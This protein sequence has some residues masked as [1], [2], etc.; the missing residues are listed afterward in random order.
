MKHLPQ[1]L[2]R[3]IYGFDPTFHNEFAK[4]LA[5]LRLLGARKTRLPREVQ[6]LREQPEFRVLSPGWKPH[7]VDLEVLYLERLY[8]LRIPFDYPFSPPLVE[9]EGRRFPAF[10][11]WSPAA[12]L[13]AA[14]M[15]C[16]VDRQAVHSST[17]PS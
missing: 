1:D 4:V 6:W 14:I 12:G 11:Y 16:H 9:H 15:T 10:D 13:S 5:H 17:C 8:R 2:Q 3:H 7:Q